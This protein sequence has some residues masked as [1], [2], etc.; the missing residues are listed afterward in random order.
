MT[1]GNQH[2]K[3]IDE[4]ESTNTQEPMTSKI[5]FFESLEDAGQCSDKILEDFSPYVPQE[6]I[7]GIAVIQEPTMLEID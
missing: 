1:L 2:P 3:N 4:K 5:I 6:P 7:T